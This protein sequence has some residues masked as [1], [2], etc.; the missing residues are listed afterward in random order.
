[1]VG[2]TCKV[3]EFGAALRLDDIPSDCLSAAATGITDCVAVTYAGADEDA[4]RLASQLVRPA[5]LSTSAPVIAT[6]VLYDAP[7]A[8]LINGIAG[9]VLDYDDVG[10]DGHPSVVLASAILAEGWALNRSGALALAAYMAGYEVWALMKELEPGKLHERGF[11]PTAVCGTLATTMACAVLHKLD[12]EKTRNAIAIGASLACG[13]VANFGT[14]T[15]SLHAGRTAQSGIIAARLAA[16]GYTGSADALEHPVGFLAAHSPSGH[17][18][19][20][21]EAIRLGQH[22]RMRDFGI[23]IKSY[24]IC[25]G[26]HRC[27]DAMLDLA[28]THKLKPEQVREIR[29]GVGKAQLVMLR[30]HAPQTGLEAKF[31]ME[32]AMASALTVGRVGL[33]QLTDAFVR[34]IDIQTLMK[35]VKSRSV[36]DGIPGLPASPGAPMHADTVEVELTD[37]SVI[38]APPVEYARG[39][40]Q[41]PLD[42]SGLL[43]KFIDCTKPKLGAQQAQMLFDQLMDLR[44]LN[45]LRDLSFGI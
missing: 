28:S 21:G 33:D 20:S 35:R 8:A 12:A 36:H 31:S 19:T 5:D 37:G 32:F 13:L 43:T 17:P 42:R 22:W 2:L 10:I 30:N 3:A 11:H 27:I 23:N 34:R 24:P 18:D 44:E 6:G 40:W 41:R 16:L 39:S 1:M 26:T 4:P 25:Y 15:K 45:S 9:H 29:V 7:D 14:M 38:V